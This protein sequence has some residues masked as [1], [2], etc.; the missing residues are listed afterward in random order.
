MTKDPKRLLEILRFL[1]QELQQEEGFEPS[2]FCRTTSEKGPQ[3]YQDLLQFEE[4]ER[5]ND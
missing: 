1:R 2:W 4:E 3:A 5:K